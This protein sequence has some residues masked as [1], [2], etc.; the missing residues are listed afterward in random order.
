MWGLWLSSY[1]ENLENV[2]STK[3]AM[4]RQLNVG[5]F[6]TV[7]SPEL[8]CRGRYPVG[9]I[10]S[11]SASRLDPINVRAAIVQFMKNGKVIKLIRRI[12]SFV[13]QS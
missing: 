4:T 11:R 2:L 8:F 13:N 7:K 6:V 1:I 9:K 3:Q 12:H 5:Y 10:I